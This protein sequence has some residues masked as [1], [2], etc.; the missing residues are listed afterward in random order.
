MKVICFFIITFFSSSFIPSSSFAS[1]GSP[2]GTVTSCGIGEVCSGVSTDY[3]SGDY[4][5]CILAPSTTYM[6][7]IVTLLTKKIVR[8]IMWLVIVG[9]G[10][11]FIF[12]KVSTGMIVLIVI[13]TAMVLAPQKIVNLLFSS[14]SSDFNLGDCSDSG[15][16]TSCPSGSLSTIA[17][18]MNS[19]YI[20][21]VVGGQLDYAKNPPGVCDKIGCYKYLCKTRTK[22]SV[23]DPVTGKVSIK[24]C[25]LSGQKNVAVW[26]TSTTF[27]DYR[28]EDGQIPDYFNQSSDCQIQSWPDGVERTYLYC[29]NSCSKSGGKYAI[30]VPSSANISTC[31]DAAKTAASN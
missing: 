1:L 16:I 15:A 22:K 30:M 8:P 25:T 28:C 26:S 14:G 2:C 13:G 18:P 31:E 23:T 12:G 21:T 3:I 24:G 4:G 19:R 11:A 10:V 9:L 27:I 20:L 5:V 29:Q 17:G 7:K 6:C